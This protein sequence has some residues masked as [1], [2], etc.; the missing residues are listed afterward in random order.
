MDYKIT[1]ILSDCASYDLEQIISYY[2]INLS[3]KKYATLLHQKIEECFNTLIIFPNMGKNINE[4]N[5]RN[6]YNIKK[7]IVEGYIIYYLFEEEN[8]LITVLR[9]VSTKR[10]DFMVL[11]QIKST[12]V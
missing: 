4:V 3:N 6:D 5:L 7:I 10:D 11:G 12:L 1:Y 2:S 9:I 8:N